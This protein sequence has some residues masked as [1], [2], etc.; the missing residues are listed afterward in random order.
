MNRGGDGQYRQN[1]YQ[2]QNRN[3]RPDGRTQGGFNKF[4]N[5]RGGNNRRQGGNRDGGYMQ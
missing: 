1:N 4:Q 2:G 5:N 3:Q